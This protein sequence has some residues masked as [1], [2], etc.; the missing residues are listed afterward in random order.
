M[1]PAIHAVVAS[2][3]FSVAHASTRAVL[4]GMLAPSFQSPLC[5]SYSSSV[6]T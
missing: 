5:K 1:S 6:L 4:Y 2:F 3:S